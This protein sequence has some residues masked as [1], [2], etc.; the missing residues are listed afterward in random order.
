MVLS[1]AISP[2]ILP[3]SGIGERSEL[4]KSVCYSLPRGFGWRVANLPETVQDFRLVR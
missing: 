1:I 4:L 3:I 2:D